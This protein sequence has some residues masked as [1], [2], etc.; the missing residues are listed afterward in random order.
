MRL[1]N[2][3]KLTNQQKERQGKEVIPSLFLLGG[4]TPSLTAGYFGFIVN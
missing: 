2:S 1:A 4:S 3:T